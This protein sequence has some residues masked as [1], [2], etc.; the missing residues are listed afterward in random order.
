M[1]TNQAAEGLRRWAN[2]SPSSQAAVI[3][4]TEACRG[5]LVEAMGSCIEFDAE[6]G[7]CFPIWEDMPEAS[8]GMSGG[9]RRLIALAASLGSNRPV[10]LE[11]ACSGLDEFNAA[12]VVAAI[13]QAAGHRFAV[14]VEF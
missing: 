2:G 9:E 6:H 5:R 8:R 3:I 1:T 7:I 13:A 14:E 11:D 10:G 4:L 12:V